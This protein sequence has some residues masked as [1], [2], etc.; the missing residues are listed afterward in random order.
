MR[1]G[2][3]EATKLY[4]AMLDIARN[5]NRIIQCQNYSVRY[6]KWGQYP[7]RHRRGRNKGSIVVGCHYFDPSTLASEYKYLVDNLPES[8]KITT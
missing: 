4:E 8:G 5:Q 7:S 1:L 6:D 3:D 2:R